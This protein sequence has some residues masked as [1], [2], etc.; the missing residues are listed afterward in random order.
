MAK[1]DE[2][3][4]AVRFTQDR[5]VDDYR[6]GTADEE[7]YKVGQVVELNLASTERWLRRGACKLV[8][9]TEGDDGAPATVEDSDAPVAI[10]GGWYL[11]PS[12]EKVHGKAATG[13]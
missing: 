13:L 7:S 1:K 8:R 4:I 12:G 5:T 10:G 6:K 11:L 2:T 9:V 3:P